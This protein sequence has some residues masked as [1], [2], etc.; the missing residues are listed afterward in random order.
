MSLIHAQIFKYVLSNGLVVL[1]NPMHNIPKVAMELWYH[2][3]SKDEKTGEKGMAHLIE[4]M[5]FKGTQKLSESDINF[6]THKL[7]GYTNAFT[8]HDA[9]AY[10]FQFPTQNWKYG[11]EILSDCMRNARFDEQMLNSEL[12]AVIQELK[13]YKDKYVNTVVEELLSVMFKDHPYHYPII[14][15]K[16]DLWNLDRQTL[17]DFYR[18]HYIPNNATLVVVGDVD[19]EE[20]FKEAEKQF[21]HIPANPDYQREQFYQGRDL[22]AKSV[23][24]TRDVQHPYVALAACL[25]GAKTK[26]QFVFDVL[27]EILG[28]GQSSRLYKKLVDELELATELSTFC[29]EMEDA[30]PFFIL[31][32]P[33]EQK[34]I[35][36]IKEII[37]KEIAHIIN[38]GITQ[39]ELDSAIRRVKTSLLHQV[40]KAEDRAHL[41]GQ[42]YFATGDE[43]FLFNFTNYACDDLEREIKEILVGYFSPSTMHCGQ[44]LPFNPQLKHDKMQWTLLQER[45]DAEDAKILN[46][47]ERILEVEPPRVADTITVHDP[48]KFDF[49][50]PEKFELSNGLKVLVCNNKELP[51]INM[52]LTLSARVDADPEHLQG[53]YDFVAEM[54]FEG[55]KQY[56]GTSIK[57]E[58]ERYG[59]TLTIS[60]GK[61]SMSMLSEDFERG[62]AFLCELLTQATFDKKPIEKIRQQFLAGLKNYWDNPSAFVGQLVKEKIYQNHPYA[63]NPHGTFESINAITQA[64]LQEYYKKWFTPCGAKIAV[65]GDLHTYHVQELLENYLGSWNGERVE[66]QDYCELQPAIADTVTY[67]ID[68]DQVVLAYAKPSITRLDDRFDKLLLFEQ[69]FSGGSMASR[70]FQLRERSGLFY[71]ITGSLTA[72]ADEQPGFFIVKTI[73][74]K[75]RLQEAEQVIKHTI[76]TVVDSLTQE[77]LDDAKQVIIN[78]LVDN[79]ATNKRMANSFLF[80]DRYNLPDTYFDTKAQ[81]IMAISLDQVKDA[82]RSLLNTQDMITFK[83]GRIQEGG[84]AL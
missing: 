41:I 18:K 7:S 24:I 46:G 32:Q 28:A 33:V 80:L 47:K 20:V 30:T 2:V 68:R 65:V 44:V 69:I 70:L 73:V 17:V 6:M 52:V 56:P 1:V 78:S 60:S 22:I 21:G 8:S 39:K 45:S 16:Q 49:K 48:K 25:P 12:K 23:T 58:L 5:I 53:L 79:F 36:V 71:T 37:Y 61:I 82:A 55:T 10:V 43:N 57:D 19:P 9:T 35:P 11:F 75:D 74:S 15:F 31:F 77:E 59:M 84:M 54:L 83:I 14:G 26:R 63:K 3:G 27:S 38:N 13:M 67:Q 40:E 34:D 81:T 64:D 51:K 62:L 29:Y 42:Y 50:K 66:Q 76:N 4:H 72:R